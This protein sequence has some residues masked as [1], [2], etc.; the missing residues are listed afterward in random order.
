[1][2]Q[3]LSRLPSDRPSLWPGGPRNRGGK[4][5]RGMDARPRA[6]FEEQSREDEFFWSQR[7]RQNIRTVAAHQWQLR[8]W[9]KAF[10]IKAR[11]WRSSIRI[12]GSPAR[13]VGIDRELRVRVQSRNG[14]PRASRELASL[15][16]ARRP[17][18]VRL[19]QLEPRPP[20]DGRGP[21][22]SWP[23]LSTFAPRT[24]R[25]AEGTKAPL[26]PLSRAK[27]GALPHHRQ[28]DKGHL[29]GLLCLQAC[30]VRQN[31]P[32]RCHQP[33]VAA[34]GF[35]F[36]RLTAKR[37]ASANSES[38]GSHKGEVTALLLKLKASS[39]PGGNCPGVGEGGGRG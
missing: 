38:N 19:C 5:G 29:E 23:R 35:H 18:G 26:W 20:E 7:C 28:T 14:N 10:G 27:I 21:F 2:V 32:A 11:G 16:G 15:K 3:K 33:E 39:L 31:T 34:T 17:L 30:S 12:R 1:M 25:V 13:G 6:G 36:A 24:L 8:V 37:V 9:S 22:F 4:P